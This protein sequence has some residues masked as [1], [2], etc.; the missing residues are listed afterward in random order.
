VSK[1]PV[2]L[3]V[4]CGAAGLLHI[5]SLLLP[6]QWPSLITYLAIITSLIA[7]VWALLWS[8]KSDLPLPL[9]LGSTVLSGLTIAS[10]IAVAIALVTSLSAPA[11]PNTII[12]GPSTSAFLFELL[13]LALLAGFT[14]FVIL[15]KQNEASLE[16][17][18]LS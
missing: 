12:R 18:S 13:H 9:R 17:N 1:P 8:L 7:S 4:L 15:M 3:L 6:G 2:L 5:F 14:T 11:E 16:E 10:L